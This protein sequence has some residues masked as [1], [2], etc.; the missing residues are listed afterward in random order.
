ML[1]RGYQQLI[2]RTKCLEST[3]YYEGVDRHGK[4]GV[5][6]PPSD[7]SLHIGHL[8]YLCHWFALGLTHRSEQPP[9]VGSNKPNSDRLSSD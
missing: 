1:V 5:V 2:V 7:P 8:L 9:E 3:P 6:W 4:V